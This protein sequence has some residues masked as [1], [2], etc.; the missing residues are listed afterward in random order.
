MTIYYVYAYLRKSDHSPYYIGKGKDGRAYDKIKH[1]IQVPDNSRIVIIAK[2]LTEIG[3]FAL[4]RRLIKW[5]GRKDIG[6]GILRNL[7]DGGNGTSGYK[8]SVSHK[9]KIRN[10]NIGK[11]VSEITKE[12]IRTKLYGKKHSKEQCKEK[13]LRQKGKP[14]SDEWKLKMTG[15]KNPLISEKL[16]GKKKPVVQCPYCKITGGVSAMHRWHFS[17]CKSNLR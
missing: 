13:S 15:R 4:E 10:A 7:T 14:K 12:K 3:A 1:R 8:Q 2:N 16:L 5:Y 9:E 6:T 11:K 17:N